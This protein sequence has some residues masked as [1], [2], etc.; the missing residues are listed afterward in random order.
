MILC[1]DEW[2]HLVISH[3]L[4]WNVWRGMPVTVMPRDADIVFT[5]VLFVWQCVSLCV[6][7]SAQKLENK[8]SEIDV[9][10][11]EYVYRS[12][13]V[14]VTFVLDLWTES[15]FTIRPNPTFFV[16]ETATRHAANA[17][18][19]SP[20]LSDTGGCRVYLRDLDACSNPIK[21]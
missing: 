5:G 2:R 8:W 15:Y 13:L 10:C 16:W 19:A 20:H 14:L 3:E 6:R 17:L 9:N 4:S 7:L 18:R 21:S 1:K 12:D 11:W